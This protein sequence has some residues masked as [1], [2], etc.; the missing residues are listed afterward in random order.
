MNMNGYRCFACAVTQ[1]AN[2]EG[3][4]CPVCGGNLDIRYDYDKAAGCIDEHFSD[5]SAD[6]FRFAALLPVKNRRSRFPLHVGGTPLYRLRRPEVMGGMGS[7]YLKDET[8]NPSASLKDRA[9]R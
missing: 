2:Y 4:V 8:V 5:A 6:L 7:V 9:A 1:S 3:F